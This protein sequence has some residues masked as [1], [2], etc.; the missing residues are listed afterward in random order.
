MYCFLP[1][2]SY[3]H[4]PV[5]NQRRLQNKKAA[6]ARKN[7]NSLS[8]EITSDRYI[9]LFLSGFLCLFLVKPLFLLHLPALNRSQRAVDILLSAAFLFSSNILPVCR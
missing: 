9:I 6:L 7:T 2:S 5:Q 3:Y 4:L 1:D 8:V